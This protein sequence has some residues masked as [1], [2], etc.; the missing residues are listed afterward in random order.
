MQASTIDMTYDNRKINLNDPPAW[1]KEYLETLPCCLCGSLTCDCTGKSKITKP[2]IKSKPVKSE[3][4]PKPVKLEIDSVCS[5]YQDWIESQIP[6]MTVKAIHQE[7]QKKFGFP[8]SYTSVK[9]FVRK[10]KGL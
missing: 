7:L 2:E 9:D 10:L 1:Y 5:P 3:I 4:K 6:N 8:N